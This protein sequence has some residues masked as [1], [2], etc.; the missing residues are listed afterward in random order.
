MLEITFATMLGMLESLY[1]IKFPS[2]LIV[3]HR[4]GPSNAAGNFVDFRPTMPVTL[5][6]T[7]T[8][9]SWATLDSF[10]AVRWF[11]ITRANIMRA[12]G[13]V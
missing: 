3:D 9:Y 7:A 13:M 1:A 12:R 5:F 6:M 8:W 4:D 10:R 11:L 2:D